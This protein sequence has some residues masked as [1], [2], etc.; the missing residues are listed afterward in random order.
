MRSLFGLV[1]LISASFL[2]QLLK[3]ESTEKSESI[4]EKLRRAEN[5]PGVIRSNLGVTR[6]GTRIPCL[7]SK[8]DLD[9]HSTKT[10]VLI[11]A[12]FQNKEDT[13]EAIELLEWFYTN[14]DAKPF[15][16]TFSLSAV[17][18]VNPDEADPPAFPVKGDAYFSKD[19]PEAEYLWRWIGMHAPDI[20]VVLKSNN[21]SSQQLAGALAK[22][23]PCQTGKI[24]VI[25]ADFPPGDEAPP[26]YLKGLIQRLQAS[27]ETGPSPARLELQKRVDRE[28]LEIAGQLAKVYGH[29]LGSVQYIPALALVGRLWLGELTKDPAPR[30]DVER[31][32]APYVSGEKKTLPKRFGGS[33]LAGH[34]IFT[35]LARTAEKPAEKQ[36]YLELARIAA[37]TGFDESGQARPAMP[38]HNEMSDAVFMACPILV[39]TGVQTGEKKYLKMAGKHFA[40]MQNLVLRPDGIYRHSPLCETAWGRGNGF[41]ALG[42]AWSLTA[43]PED[44]A[45]FPEFR[46]AFQKHMAALKKHQDPTGMWHQ[47]VDDDG[48]YRELSSTCMITFSLI[49]GVRKGW[50]KEADYRP[51][52][53]KAF[54]AIKTRI[55]ADG[56]LVDVCTGTGKQKSLRDYY[57]R[58]A[59]L[60]KDARGGAMALLVT[61]EMARWQAESK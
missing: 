56:T 1:V 34:L 6:K 10:R 45:L 58:K 7:Y 40:F 33:H 59:I 22:S 51:A 8:E 27:Q 43:L 39:E 42:L 3:A 36:R 17:P 47:V 29:D 60:G 19:N 5:W 44:H 30:K 54:R 25:H 24:P 26:P 48:S 38:A 53:E 57:D 15:R 9:P 18:L 11:V 35:E 46:Q 61:T 13:S 31:I 37:D 28:P 16:K 32:V 50:L 49:R 4:E 52:I 55:A 41:P 21:A 23:A 12:G 2:P 14:D 20:V